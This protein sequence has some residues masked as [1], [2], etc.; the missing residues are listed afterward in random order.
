[1][2]LETT[3]EH[4]GTRIR[5]HGND[6]ARIYPRVRFGG[7]RVRT[8][9]QPRFFFIR[10]ASCPFLVELHNSDLLSAFRHRTGVDTLPRPPKA[11]RGMLLR[12][13]QSEF[14]FPRPP[15][16][17]GIVNVTPDSFSDGGQ[18]ADPAQAVS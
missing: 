8:Q 10:V 3:N 5:R 17:M 16:V 11:A 6:A 13:R 9:N 4:Q 12:A 2:Q 18:S 1:M 7:L 15:L 14:Q